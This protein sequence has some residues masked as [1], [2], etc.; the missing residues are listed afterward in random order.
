MLRQDAHRKLSCLSASPVF[1]G[2]WNRAPNWNIVIWDVM[3]SL[4][5]K[6]NT[7][8]KEPRSNLVLAP[9]FCLLILFSLA[10]FRQEAG[11][12]PKCRKGLRSIGGLNPDSLA[13]FRKKGNHPVA[14]SGGTGHHCL[15]PRFVV[16]N[17]RVGRRR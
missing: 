4:L 2:L 17:L 1:S 7:Q 12:G 8:P 16:R 11:P 9:D 15:L 10:S 14:V 5:T 13:L 3:I 6:V